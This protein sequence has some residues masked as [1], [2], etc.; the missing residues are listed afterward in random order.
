MQHHRL[1]RVALPALALT[2]VSACL[3]YARADPPE[4]QPLQPPECAKPK[5]QEQHFCCVETWNDDSGKH[6]SDCETIGADGIKSCSL[7]GGA[8]LN[9]AASW[10]MN[11]TGVVTCD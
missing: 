9:C 8:V 10:D 1:F 11:S 5:V 3:G 2:L 4:V 6:G 7:V